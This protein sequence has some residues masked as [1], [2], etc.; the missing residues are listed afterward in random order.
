MDAVP[1]LND[2]VGGVTV[3][4]EDDIPQLGPAY[5]KGESVTLRGKEALRFVRYRDTSLL[6]DN[7]RRMGHHRLISMLLQKRH[8]A[9]Y[10]GIRIWQ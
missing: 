9:H 4:L 10:R 2:L 6:D 1:L 8:A 5:R 3:K 7:L